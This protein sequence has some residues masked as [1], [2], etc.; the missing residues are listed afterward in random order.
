MAGRLRWDVESACPGCGFA[1]AECG[2]D[3][4]GERR[5]HLLAA[6]GPARLR[7]SDA[8]LAGRVR[9]MRVLRAEAGLD[10]AGARAE[11]WRVLDGE[12][13]G[14][15]PEM[16]LLAGKLRAVGV[17]AAAVRER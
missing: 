6:H 9:I 5:E 14:T 16:E 15:L 17:D 11:A 2:G 4:P 7:V 10:P 1:L 12:Y 13:A 8:G 3:L